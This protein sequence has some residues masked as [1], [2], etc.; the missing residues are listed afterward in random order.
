VDTGFK[1][2]VLEIPPALAARA[3]AKNAPVRLKLVAPVWSPEKAL[4]TADDR[5]LGVMVDRVAVK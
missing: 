1:P 3:A 4:G 5:E 2:Y